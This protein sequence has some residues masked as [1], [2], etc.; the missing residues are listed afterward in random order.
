MDMMI[1]VVVCKSFTWQ[2]QEHSFAKNTCVRVELLQLM[3]DETTD[4]IIAGL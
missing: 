1:C 4:I 3:M 2:G